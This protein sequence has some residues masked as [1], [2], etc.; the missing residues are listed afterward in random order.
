MV[1]D[2]QR[3]SLLYLWCADIMLRIGWLLAVLG[4]NSVYAEAYCLPVVICAGTVVDSRLTLDIQLRNDE[5]LI[6]VPMSEAEYI[7]PFVDNCRIVYSECSL[8]I[9]CVVMG[10]CNGQFAL[11]TKHFILRI[12]H[13]L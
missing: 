11:D 13:L 8:F 5:K 4:T 6:G 10:I 9:Q 1:C 7:H 3:I 2:Y 12:A